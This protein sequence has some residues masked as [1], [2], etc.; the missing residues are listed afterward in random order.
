MVESVFWSSPFVKNK[1][2]AIVV[3]F[4]RNKSYAFIF[5]NKITLIPNIGH[6]FKINGSFKSGFFPECKIRQMCQYVPFL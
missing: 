6:P 4:F 1:S 5:N 2:V 3:P